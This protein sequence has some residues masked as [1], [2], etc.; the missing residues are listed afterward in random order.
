[1]CFGLLPRCKQ[2]F[3]VEDMFK[4]PPT[5]KIFLVCACWSGQHYIVVLLTLQPLCYDSVEVPCQ[6]N[7]DKSYICVLQLKGL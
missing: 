5:A 4:M 6:V 7:G 2:Y 3:R 1:M